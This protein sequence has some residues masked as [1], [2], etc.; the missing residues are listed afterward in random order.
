MARTN[1]KLIAYASKDVT[2]ENTNPLLV[3]LQ[4][5]IAGRQ[6]SMAIPQEDGNSSS[7]RYKYT[8]FGHMQT[9]P[10]SY[11]RDT[12]SIVFIA[13]IFKIHINW[14]NRDVPD[15]TNKEMW[16]IYTKNIIQSLNNKSSNSL[17][18]DKTIIYSL[19]TDG[20][21]SLLKT[22]STQIVEYR[23]VSLVPI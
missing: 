5:C 15:H 3:G 2:K 10:S 12:S 22:T 8:T 6:S 14:K 17:V 20:K 11:H 19:Q 23:E 7:S 21:A 9:Y 4:N 13:A 18:V 1:K 16:Y